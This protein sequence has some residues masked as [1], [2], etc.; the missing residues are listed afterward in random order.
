[1]YL[2]LSITSYCTHPICSYAIVK[3][4]EMIDNQK[5]MLLERQVNLYYTVSISFSFPL[6]SYKHTHTERK[7]HAKHTTGAAKHFS[8]ECF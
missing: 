7:R 3:P 1:M 8:S 4:I 2:V 6:L 5:L